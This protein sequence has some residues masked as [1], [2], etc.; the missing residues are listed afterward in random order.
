[1][2]VA[3]QIIILLLH[4]LVENC[5]VSKVPPWMYLFTH[6]THRKRRRRLDEPHCSLCGW[7]EFDPP[8]KF[9]E[10]CKLEMSASWCG[11]CSSGSLCRWKEPPMSFRWH[12][13][14]C[15]SPCVH[16]SGWIPA[17]ASHLA[18]SL[19]S[20]WPWSKEAWPTTSSRRRW[21]SAL[22]W[23]YLPQSTCRCVFWLI[24]AAE[25]TCSPASRPDLRSLLCGFWP[26]PGV[27]T[28]DQRVVQGGGGGRHLRI[29]SGACG[30]VR[31]ETSFL[32]WLKT[33]WAAVRCRN[34]WTRMSRRRRRAIPGGGP[35]AKP[36][37]RCEC[38]AR[39][40][41]HRRVSRISS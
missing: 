31:P 40:V 37:G 2:A 4:A 26:S 36:A 19:P 13:L 7:T 30:S 25:L 27:W 17:S 11:R 5:P 1:M 34:I 21:T 8:S 9:K 29:W 14:S 20:T 22:T 15:K 39:V 12:S 18:T 35:S 28:A 3:Y 10:D 32:F 38:T 23:G 16:V 41:S 24:P 6:A 33:K